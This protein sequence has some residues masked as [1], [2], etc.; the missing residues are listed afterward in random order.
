MVCVPVFAWVGGWPPARDGGTGC[1]G[2]G[3]RMEESRSPSLVLLSSPPFPQAGAPHQ[4]GGEKVPIQH[5]RGCPT[6][7]PPLSPAG[8]RMSSM[9]G[10]PRASG[11]RTP[12]SPL[13]ECNVAIL[14]CRG[15]GKSGE[16]GALLPRGWPGIGG[17]LVPWGDTRLTRLFHLLQ[18]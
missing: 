11:E 9:F 15:A 3:M 16:M 7:P 10:K 5:G 6:F 2:S 8:Q 4:P 13:A 17:V 12:Q 18:P 14:G 1:P